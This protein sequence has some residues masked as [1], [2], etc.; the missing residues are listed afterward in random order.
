M[1]PENTIS[2]IY[3]FYFVITFCFQVHFVELDFSCH[4]KE[5]F[6]MVLGQK[7]FFAILYWQT[8]WMVKNVFFALP[9]L[10]TDLWSKESLTPYRCLSLCSPINKH[11]THLN[12]S[13]GLSIFMFCKYLWKFAQ[14]RCLHYFSFLFFWSCDYQTTQSRPL[15]EIT[16]PFF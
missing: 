11:S 7:T 9:Y 8:L 6:L 4:F 5:F 2:T 3:I 12:I 1:C 15:L 10:F 13:S 16:A 14:P